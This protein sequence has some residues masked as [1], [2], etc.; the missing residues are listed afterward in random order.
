[1]LAF[2]NV[3]LSPTDF[4]VCGLAIG[5]AAGLAYLSTVILHGRPVN[6]ERK[7]P[8]DLDDAHIA[9]LLRRSRRGP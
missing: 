5:L 6:R 4:I 8:Y 9:R 2:P 3:P 7:H 1:M